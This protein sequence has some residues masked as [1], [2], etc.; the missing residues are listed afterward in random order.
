LPGAQPPQVPPQ[1]TSVSVPLRTPSV[2]DGPTQTFPVQLA[3]ATQSLVAWH[4][5]PMAQGGHVPPPQSVPVSAPFATPSEQLGAAHLK[6]VHTPLVQSPP[7]LHARPSPQCEQVPPQS[8]SVS[9]PFFAPSV[10]VAATHHP[11]VQTALAQSV[12]T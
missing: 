3:P 11:P 1:S 9:V 10:H 12:P 5:T 4:P 6:S 2:H 8:V 7:N